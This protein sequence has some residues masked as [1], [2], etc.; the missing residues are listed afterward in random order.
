M[1]VSPPTPI[2]FI[3]LMLRLKDIA[4]RIIAAWYL[5]KQDTGFP[6]VNFNSWNINGAGQHIDVQGNHKQ[7]VF[8][9]QSCS[10]PP[11]LTSGPYALSGLL[12][13]SC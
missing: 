3:S 10:T 6:S 5:L 4:L 7:R 2:A 11:Y 13:P 12:R 9:Y 1:Y 8:F